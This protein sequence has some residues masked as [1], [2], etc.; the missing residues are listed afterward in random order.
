VK[1]GLGAALLLFACRHPPPRPAD[2]SRPREPA[3]PDPT[4][5]FRAMRRADPRSWWIDEHGTPQR[6]LVQGTRVE[7]EGAAIRRADTWFTEPLRAAWEHEGRWQ[8]VGRTARWDATSFLGDLR[9]DAWT[10]TGMLGLGSGRAVIVRDGVAEGLGLP[11]GFVLDAAFGDEQ[12]GVAILEPGTVVLT[13]DG[14]GRWSPVALR[15]DTPLEVVALDARRWIRGAVGCH[16]VGADGSLGAAAC[17]SLPWLRDEMPSDLEAVQVVSNSWLRPRQTPLTFTDTS[18]RQV[19][20]EAPAPDGPGNHRPTTRVYDLERDA[21]VAGPGV[22]LPCEHAGREDFFVADRLYLRCPSSQG[23]A[24][25]ALAPGGRWAERL[26]TSGCPQESACAAS[27]DGRRVTCGGRCDERTTCDGESWFCERVGDGAPRQWSAGPT[28]RGWRVVGYEGDAPVLIDGRGWLG[29]AEFRRGDGATEPLVPDADLAGF[30]RLGAP[31]L[32]RDGL[33][34]FWA[35][36]ADGGRYVALEGRPGGPF[37]VR[38]APPWASSDE[39]RV[40]FRFCGDDGVAMSDAP[41]GRA[42]IAHGLND[43]W[44]PLELDDDPAFAPLRGGSPTGDDRIYCDALGWR[45]GGREESVVGWGR[46]APSRF[47]AVVAA[48][49]D[50]YAQ[51]RPWRCTPR[52]DDRS[53]GGVAPWTERFVPTSNAGPLRANGGSIEVWSFALTT[54]SSP[55]PRAFRYRAGAPGTA[56]PTERGWTV[57]TADAT[58]ATVLAWV[59]EPASSSLTARLMVLSASASPRTLDPLPDELTASSV[60]AVSVAVAREGAVT[61]TLVRRLRDMYGV[62]DVAVDA[63]L[64]TLRTGAR[65]AVRRASIAARGRPP[66]PYVLDGVTG[67]ARL[68]NDGSVVGAPPGDAP[69]VLARSTTVA[70]CGP[71]ARGAFTFEA[72]VSRPGSDSAQTDE[73]IE[74]YALDGEALCL[75]VLRTPDVTAAPAASGVDGVRI[76]G[77]PMRCTRP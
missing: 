19:L 54:P 18:R 53:L 37:V 8:F 41:D 5:R 4:A 72:E 49:L 42:W 22:E 46:P 59:R 10:P 55:S 69:R 75:R 6:G 58:G 77:A 38:P 17:A 71:S 62:P 15:G 66:G 47:G 57:L 30:R 24:L 23:T 31:R 60:W 20:V 2:V 61:A 16:A 50:Q 25:H 43:R 68:R 33:V 12:R 40:T 44:R 73:A 14:G 32:G 76:D 63:P 67:V 74:E 65:P 21:L 29:H 26:R 45:R 35:A 3:P 64:V 7:V 28:E 70:P 13:D 9:R 1:R 48:R 52:G 36:R 56:P 39:G 51:A 11:P 34:R 27:A